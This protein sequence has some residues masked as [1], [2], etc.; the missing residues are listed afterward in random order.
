LDS[1]LVKIEL[2]DG[3]LVSINSKGIPFKEQQFTGFDKRIKLP[4]PVASRKN[5]TAYTPRFSPG[6]QQ[7]IN[8]YFKNIPMEK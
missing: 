1:K 7:Y 8:T 2:Q 3:T 5:S 4:S 6:Q